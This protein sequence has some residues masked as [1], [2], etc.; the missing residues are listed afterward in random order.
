[1]TTQMDTI[2][3]TK[4]FKTA[5]IFTTACLLLGLTSCLH[6]P[7]VPFIKPNAVKQ[8]DNQS[9]SKI[10]SLIFSDLLFESPIGDRAFSSVKFVYDQKDKK[11]INLETIIQKLIR[12]ESTIFCAASNLSKHT[13]DIKFDLTNSQEQEKIAVTLINHSSKAVVYTNQYL[14]KTK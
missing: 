2:M 12:K 3:T 9:I 1:M 10:A 8:P 13:F 6:S 5:L 11:L 14:L 4:T 7:D